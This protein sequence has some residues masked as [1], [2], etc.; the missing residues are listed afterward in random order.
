MNQFLGT[1]ALL[2]VGKIL[3][4]LISRDPHIANQLK[5]F[6]NKIIE[7]VSRSPSLSITLC[8]D[9]GLVKL[10]AIDSDTLL[11]KPDAVISGKAADLL[12]LLLSPAH[13]RALANTAISIRGDAALVQDLFNLLMELDID[14]EDHLAPLFGNTAIGDTITNE[15]S[16]FASR[17]GDWSRDAGQSIRRNINDYLKEEIRAVPA[18]EELNS[19]SDNLDQLR[20][21]IDRATARAKQLQS[22]LGKLLK[23]Q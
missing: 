5:R 6:D 10:S 4:G 15:A 12:E 1:L 7:V 19:F 18:R 20:L 9:D 13:S 21:H 22:R 3:N 14:W 17:A 8:F 11:L 23:S 16:K 2:P